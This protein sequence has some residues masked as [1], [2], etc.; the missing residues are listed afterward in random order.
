MEPH[1]LQTISNDQNL[2]NNKNN[3]KSYLKINP[4]KLFNK[5][6]TKICPTWENAGGFLRFYSI[7]PENGDLLGFYCRASIV[8]NIMLLALRRNNNTT[9][10]M[11]SILPDFQLHL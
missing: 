2:N 6:C 1:L 8:Y 9:D 11:F 5:N 7:L 4:K 3:I 10:T